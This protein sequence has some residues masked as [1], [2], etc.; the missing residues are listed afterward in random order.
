M[1]RRSRGSLHRKRVAVEGGGAKELHRRSVTRGLALRHGRCGVWDFWRQASYPRRDGYSGRQRETTCG[2]LL[3][4][5][6]VVNHSLPGEESEPSFRR[7]RRTVRRAGTGLVLFVRRLTVYSIKV[8]FRLLLLC[9][10]GCGVVSG[11]LSPP[12]ILLARQAVTAYVDRCVLRRVVW[13]AD[14]ALQYNGVRM[15]YVLATVIGARRVRVG[16]P[17]DAPRVCRAQ[18]LLL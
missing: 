2:V 9:V 18:H 10:V 5:L 8:F 14:R 17:D 4:F 7:T 13:P 16:R 11:T 1:H 6:L 12:E 3:F 15:A